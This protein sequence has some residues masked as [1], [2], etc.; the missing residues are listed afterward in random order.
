MDFRHSERQCG[1]MLSAPGLGASWVLSFTSC[2][3]LSK[4]LSLS[5]P[6]L[7]QR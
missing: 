7:S 6:H 5:V 3:T 4:L 2:V 1:E